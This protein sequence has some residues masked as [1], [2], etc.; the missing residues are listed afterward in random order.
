MKIIAFVLSFLLFVQPVFALYPGNQRPVYKREIGYI[1]KENCNAI[2]IVPY[3]GLSYYKC[4]SGE[5]FWSEVLVGTEGS[6]LFMLFKNRK[7]VADE[8]THDVAAYTQTY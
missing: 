3:S 5:D 1:L 4:P 2:A 8:H 6:P 7:K